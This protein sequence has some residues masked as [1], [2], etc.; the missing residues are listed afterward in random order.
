MNLEAK[1]LKETEKMQ[2]VKQQK[3]KVKQIMYLKLI[4][5]QEMI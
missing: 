2:H 4:E 5:K 1:E 3:E